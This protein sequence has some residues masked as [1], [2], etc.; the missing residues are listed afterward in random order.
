MFDDERRRFAHRAGE[1]AELFDFVTQRRIFEHGKE[2]EASV[3]Q[4]SALKTG[5]EFSG[6]AVVEQYDTTVYVPAGFR[7]SVDRWHNLIGERLQ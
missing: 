2:V 3:Y 7:V 1:R 6:P 4:R 5:D